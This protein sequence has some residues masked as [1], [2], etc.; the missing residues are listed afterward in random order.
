MKLSINKWLLGQCGREDSVGKLARRWVNESAGGK[1]TDQEAWIVELEKNSEW[2]MAVLD[3]KKEYAIA[4]E[5]LS[6][7]KSAPTFPRLFASEDY[8]KQL[9]QSFDKHKAQPDLSAD[10][11]LRR[12]HFALQKALKGRKL[13]YL[14]T[15]HWIGLRHVLLASRHAQDEYAEALFLLNDL[16]QK[17]IVLCPISFP[18][19]LELMKQTD[20]ETRGVTAELMEAFSGGVCFRFPEELQKL[21]LRQHV[22]KAVLGSKAP[23]LKEWIWTKVGYVAGELLPHKIK[24]FQML[25]TISF[26]KFQLMECGKC[27]LNTSL[28]STPRNSSPMLKI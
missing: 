20:L 22:M 6:R 8:D 13:I 14:D 23:D 2:S 1:I 16:V 17:E 11:Y 9:Q 24:R 15:N 19:F 12:Q 7:G 4:A 10:A 26:G 3:V 21:E 25:K 28:K 5:C 27:R 18:L